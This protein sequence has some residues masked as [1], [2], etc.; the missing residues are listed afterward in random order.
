[1]LDCEV[2]FSSLM[3]L[4]EDFIGLRLCVWLSYMYYI[5]LT[6]PAIYRLKVLPLR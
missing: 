5:Y 3:S 1:M 2:R 4:R 6:A